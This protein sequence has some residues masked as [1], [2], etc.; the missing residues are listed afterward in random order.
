MNAMTRPTTAVT[1]LCV[2][3]P[4]GA[5]VVLASLAMW[6]MDSVAHQQVRNYAWS[7]Q[8]KPG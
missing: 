4:T 5:T 6:E 8:P 2:Q 1:M 7:A 3:I